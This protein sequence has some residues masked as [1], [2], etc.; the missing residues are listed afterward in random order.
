MIRPDKTPSGS[1]PGKHVLEISLYQADIQSYPNWHHYG[2]RFLL[3]KY[4][5]WYG[6]LFE[7]HFGERGKGYEVDYLDVLFLRYLA[8]NM[9]KPSAPSVKMPSSIMG[10]ITKP[11]TLLDEGAEW[12]F[13]H[14]I[15]RNTVNWLNENIFPKKQRMNNEQRRHLHMSDKGM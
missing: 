3:L 13:T 12:F 15:W 7:M 1:S 14:P 8:K 2:I 4:N 5:T 10:S 9:K 11:W 6:S